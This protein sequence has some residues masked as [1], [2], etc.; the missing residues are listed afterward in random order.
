MNPIQNIKWHLQL[1]YVYYLFTT[2]NNSQCMLITKSPDYYWTKCPS[3]P[4]AIKMY[5]HISFNNT[6][7][8]P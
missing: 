6:A 1:K 2:A 8:L 3:L 7:H 4:L 5:R